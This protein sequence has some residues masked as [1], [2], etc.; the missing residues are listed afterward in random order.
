MLVK[1]EPG[2]GVH[3]VSWEAPASWPRGLYFVRIASREGVR[4]LRMTLMR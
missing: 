2:A 4:T 1:G 3:R